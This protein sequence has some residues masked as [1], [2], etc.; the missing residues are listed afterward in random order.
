MLV[1]AIRSDPGYWH[2]IPDMAIIRSF[3][4]NTWPM[5][6]HWPNDRHRRTLKLSTAELQR[7]GRIVCPYLRSCR[8]N[9]P[10][11]FAGDIDNV[12]HPWKARRNVCEPRDNVPRFQP[13]YQPV[14]AKIVRIFLVFRRQSAT[15]MALSR[16]SL[17]TGSKQK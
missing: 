7:A 6:V 11:D 3:Q 10:E 13:F 4:V 14:L 5:S 15:N 16:I 2:Q 1:S 9:Y 17:V 8:A 12:E